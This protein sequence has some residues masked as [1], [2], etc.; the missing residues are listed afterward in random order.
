M[1]YC[2]LLVVVCVFVVTPLR[3]ISLQIA[4]TQQIQHERELTRRAKDHRRTERQS[5]RKN[6]RIIDTVLDNTNES[7]PAEVR[8]LNTTSKNFS[9][10]SALTPEAI[11]QKEANVFVW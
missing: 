10:F 11:A 6:A 7:S 3:I 2:T 1:R 4:S 9:D 5:L 8:T